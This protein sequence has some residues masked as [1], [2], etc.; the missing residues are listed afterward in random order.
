MLV[1]QEEPSARTEIV[2]HRFVVMRLTR[3]INKILIEEEVCGIREG[4]RLHW[5]FKTLPHGS[6][7]MLTKFLDYASLQI[8]QLFVKRSL[9]HVLM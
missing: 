8:L 6:V 1:L 2:S 5:G 7:N 4:K 9:Q 3:I